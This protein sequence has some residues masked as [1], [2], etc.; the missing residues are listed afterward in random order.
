V[1]LTRLYLRNFRVYEDELDLALPPGL[2]GIYGANGAGKSTLLEAI[3]FT[4]WGKARTGRDEIRSAGVGADCVTELEFEHEGHLYVVRRSLSGINSTMRAEAHCDGL[5]MAEGA[6]DTRR[7]VHAVLGMDDLAFKASV[8]AEQKQLAAF[9]SQAPAE[10]RKLVLQL[11]GIT[12]LD[13]ARDAARRDA[14]ETE[15][16]LTQLR[17]V[18]P[19]ITRLAV[20][21]ADAEARAAA[22]EAEAATEA[23]VVETA[24]AHEAAATA[25]FLRHDGV[26]QAYDALVIEGRA[27]KQHL[28]RETEMVADLARELDGLQ[29]AEVELAAA[30]AAA[31]GLEEDRALLDA[32]QR[33]AEAQRRRDAIVVG[34]TPPVA[35]ETA[36]LEAAAEAE[37]AREA[38]AAHTGLLQGATDDR[39]R[40]H[41]A[42]QRSASLSDAGDCPLCGQTLGDAFARVQAHRAG[43]VAAADQRVRLLETARAQAATVAAS[44]AAALQSANAAWRAAALARS[45]WEQSDRRRQD[46]EAQITQAVRA[47]P[48]EAGVSATD[49]RSAAS[50]AALAARIG[51]RVGDKDRA[52]RHALT[53]Q[54]RLERRPELQRNLTTGRERVA[55]ADAAVVGLR[56]KVRALDFQPAA[57]D[58]ATTARQQANDRLRE[59]EVTAQ[60][61]G[62]Q[63]ARDRQ[64]AEGEALRLADGT[65]QHE[66]LADLEGRTRHLSRLAVLLSEFR[67][68]VVASVGPRLAAQAA[69]LFGEL[70]D[71]E[72]DQLQVDPDTYELQ[73]SDGGHVYGLD[74]FSGSEIDLANLALRV[75]ISEHV[76]FQSGGSVGLLVLDEIFGPLDEDRKARM[77][78]ALEQLRGRFRQ[79]MVVT[80]DSAIKEQLPNA[81]EVVKLP[82]RRATARLMV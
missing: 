22:T 12:P 10:R 62:L 57:L 45:E 37:A 29:A 27:A 75:A 65:A 24:R 47:V 20:S 2:V 39:R 80:H 53:L 71:N 50:T 68:T 55:A 33:V 7:Y 23:A 8:F 61:I 48:P 66:L 18:L 40:A 60:R 77:L 64:A 3:T 31:V 15:A 81:I 13:A 58:A 70:T 69:E 17:S 56:N 52:A 76:R 1:L 43:E 41:E 36:R 51:V 44:A 5:I 67:N 54:G 6:T 63:A 73:I 25:E 32:L 35:D 4:L 49:I 82:G 28:D 46:A 9:S 72:Y 30:G 74:R 79:V 38:L 14:R 16:Q 34:P 11:L 42:A 26:R 21:A 59:A 78:Q 19:D